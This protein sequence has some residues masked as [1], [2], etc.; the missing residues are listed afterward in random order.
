MPTMM[1]KFFWPSYG[2]TLL[3][4]AAIL[5]W[6]LSGILGGGGHSYWLFSFYAI[7]PGTVFVFG[8][9]LGFRNARLKWL[10]PFL[11]WI[12]ARVIVYAV[13]FHPSGT[14]P[15]ISWFPLVSPFLPLLY[16]FSGVIIGSLVRLTVQAMRNDT[17]LKLKKAAKI[18]LVIVLVIAAIHVAHALT[19]D[20][21]MEYTEVSFSSPNVPPELNGYRIAFIAD[22][23][24]LSGTRLREIVEE[25]SSRQIDLLLLGGDFPS[26][27]E[28]PRRSMEILSQTVTTDGIFGVEG[29][30]DNYIT[31][32]AAMEEYGITPLSNSGLLLRENFFLAG[33]EDLWN[34][35]PNIAAAI[36]N[37]SP[38]DFVLL[39]S[40]NPDV[41]MQQD[42]TGLD[43]VLSGHTHGGQ[44]T[45]F[46]IWAPY[47]TFRSSITD[48]GQHFR[49]GWALSRDDTPVFVSRGSGE[50]LPRVFSR[51]QVVLITLSNE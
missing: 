17:R 26:L 22:T 13:F 47:F 35:N 20:R 23:H 8:S 24:T 25:L 15:R 3:V 40:H 31:L 33:V 42:T 34:R 4:F 45:F 50:Y 28:A 46:G 9:V 44:I 27:G 37:A 18:A 38:D 14:F 49:S 19:L 39:V 51:P 12:L 43:L 11:T 48:Y 36:E 41:T 2:I 16:A 5:L 1:K 10:Y 30:H 21:I 29:N 6:G 32:F 7:I